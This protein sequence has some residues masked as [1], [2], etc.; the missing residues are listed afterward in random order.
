MATCL[1][2]GWTDA[3]LTASGDF[4]I[5]RGDGTYT[6]GEYIVAVSGCFTDNESADATT[7]T[8]PVE[9]TSPGVPEETTLPKHTPSLVTQ[10]SS[11][12]GEVGTTITD[13]V[14][15]AGTGVATV[16]SVWPLL[17]PVEPKIR[18]G[19][20]TC[21]GVNWAGAAVAAQGEFTAT[22]EGT[23][24]VGEFT[25]VRAGCSTYVKSLGGTGTTAPFPETPPGLPSETTL[26][27]SG[28]TIETQINA[29]R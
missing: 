28:P 22:G 26:I 10:I 29:S 5:D 15:V 8:G 19:I 14:T 23:Y 24:T 16:T 9:W 2:L 1:G 7:S 4:A 21:E 25:V 20:R 13:A 3:P 27:T 12:M 6:V 17:G 18:S 11:Q